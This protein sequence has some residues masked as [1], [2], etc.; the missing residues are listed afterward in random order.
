MECIL[1]AFLVPIWC[2]RVLL[3]AGRES[4]RMGSRKVEVVVTTNI[5]LPFLL[6]PFWF[7]EWINIYYWCCQGKKENLKS[8]LLQNCYYFPYLR[9]ICLHLYGFTGISY[10]LTP[11]IKDILM[12]ST[13]M[14]A[15]RRSRPLPLTL[16][17]CKL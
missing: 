13:L 17:R 5:P 4:E 16:K 9:F 7:W 6:G 15:S 11:L 8:L 10:S 14:F 2:F 1:A 3:S 12:I